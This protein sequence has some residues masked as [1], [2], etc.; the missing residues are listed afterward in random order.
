MDVCGGEGVGGLGG[1][2]E[3]CSSRLCGICTGMTALVRLPVGGESVAALGPTR[4]HAP[5]FTKAPPQPPGCQDRSTHAQILPPCAPLTS[6][7]L[8]FV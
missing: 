2:A 3:Q 8:R 1:E 7:F 4:C 5:G 6:L